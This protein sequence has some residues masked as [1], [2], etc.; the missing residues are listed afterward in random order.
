MG[1]LSDAYFADDLFSAPLARNSDP[2][3]SHEAAADATLNAGTNRA[4]VL[5]IHANK[6]A[7]LTDYELAD[8]AH[9]QQNS[10]GKRRGELRDAGLIEQTEIR[11]PAPSGSM[12]IVWRITPAG[13]DYFR[14]YAEAPQ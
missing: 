2:V 13:R 10:A 9:L 4:L 14:R 3:T 8:L 6:P 5:T 1:R 11:R 12:A 7:G